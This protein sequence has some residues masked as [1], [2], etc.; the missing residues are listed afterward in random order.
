[1]QENDREDAY[2]SEILRTPRELSLHGICKIPA[3]KAGKAAAKQYANERKAR[4]KA[5]ARLAEADNKSGIGL[6][7]MLNSEDRRL[8]RYIFKKLDKVIPFYVRALSDG[9][10][11]M[12][13]EEMS[14]LMEA[15]ERRGYRTMWLD[16][17]GTEKIDKRAVLH[18]V[19]GELVRV[20]EEPAP[21]RASAEAE[22]E[23]ETAVV[24]ELTEPEMADAA[25][26]MAEVEAETEATVE[27]ELGAPD[28]EIA[29]ETTDADESTM[30]DEEAGIET[31][32]A[33]ESTNNLEESIE[34]AD[35]EII[36]EEPCE[37]AE[38]VQEEPSLSAEKEAGDMVEAY[39]V[40][41]EPET[42]EKT[43]TVNEA[44]E[45]P[46]VV[47]EILTTEEKPA[48]TEE[49]ATKESAT[50]EAPA[51]EAKPAE[52]EKSAAEEKTVT[53]EKPAAKEE[54][55]PEEKPAPRRRSR[56]TSTKAEGEKA[57]AKPRR[58][59]EPAA[60]LTVEATLAKR[61]RQMGLE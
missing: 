25:L 6:L 24:E 14:W 30:P 5:L 61:R 46:V 56:K 35:V 20:L 16:L 36:Q 54:P 41:A 27:E 42:E 13:A 22:V 28:E 7:V 55:V 18:L 45:S 47:E 59:R 43:E 23:A 3:G 12:S 50:E 15:C 21:E 60:P 1:L 48:V 9:T 37:K 32:G 33:E 19:A 29:S 44:A 52:E 10:T 17:T 4:K 34:R 57:P 11:A 31:E 26:E 40:Q 51:V 53:E 49:P 39:A 2:M 38:T 58:K 8:G